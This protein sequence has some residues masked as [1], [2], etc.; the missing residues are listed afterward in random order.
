[1]SIRV[2]R[3]AYVEQ[4]VVQ[5]ITTMYPARITLAGELPEPMTAD[6]A[7]PGL[8]QVIQSP[9]TDDGI[10]IAPLVDLHCFAGDHATMWDTTKDSVNAMRALGQQ[11][12]V[13]GQLIDTVV[14]RQTPGYLPWSREVPRT[15]AVYEIHLRPVP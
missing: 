13:N 14:T 11:A 7:R 9:G 10:T 5:F 1:M 4:M 8:I 2:A 3:F 12:G 15:V 6:E